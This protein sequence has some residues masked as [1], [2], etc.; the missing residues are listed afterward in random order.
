ME[1]HV[2]FDTARDLPLDAQDKL[3]KVLISNSLLREIDPELG[4]SIFNIPD[5]KEEKERLFETLDGVL[6]RVMKGVGEPIFIGSRDRWTRVKSEDFTLRP[7]RTE[8]ISD[9]SFK[10]T[11]NRTVSAKASA[12]LVRA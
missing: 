4:P 9:V 8:P 3:A 11:R 2:I 7:S 6:T 1:V 10:M 5:T 12:A